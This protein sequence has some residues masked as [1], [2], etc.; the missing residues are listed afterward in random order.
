MIGHKMSID[1]NLPEIEVL[2]WIRSEKKIDEL[3]KFI[4]KKIALYNIPISG[5]YNVSS[6]PI[7]KY[8][9]LKV[10]KRVYQ[11]QILI[12]EDDTKKSMKVLLKK[13]EYGEI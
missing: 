3:G 6:L 9:L 13:I 8:N 7:S 10:F 11:K 1:L 12:N 5:L 4:K 2:C